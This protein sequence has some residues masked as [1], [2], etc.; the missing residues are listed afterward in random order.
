MKRIIICVMAALL[1]F[2]LFFNCGAGAEDNAAEEYDYGESALEGA[3]PSEAAEILEDGGITPGNSGASFLSL[4]GVLSYIWN[5]ICQNAVSPLRLFA[6]LA[7]VVLLCVIAKSAADIPDGKLNGIFTVVGVLAGAGMVTLSVSEVLSSTMEVLRGASGFMLVFIPVFAGILAVMGKTATAAAAN[8][9]TLAATQLFS[10]L[11]I[12]F[13]AP[14][15]GTILGLSVTGAVHPELKL[16]RVSELVRKAVIWILSLLMTVFMSLLST[17][18]FVSNSSDS[19]F[20]RTAKFAV[21]SGVPIIGGTISDAVN[22]VSAGVA[23]LHSSVGTYGIIA[24][25]VIILPCLIGVLCY[26]FALL[27]AEVLGDVFGISELSEL[28]RACGAVMTIIIAVIA[29]FLLMNTIAA[30]IM[31]LSGNTE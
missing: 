10:Q 4:E 2:I 23:A 19:I 31:L 7:G 12:N 3:L 11:A 20:I 6:S 13:L 30:V 1:I 24:G 5:I 25:A 28:F 26:R 9:V 17:Q 14:L 15:C 8:A 27:A 22:T 16:S 21:S 29:C 18:T